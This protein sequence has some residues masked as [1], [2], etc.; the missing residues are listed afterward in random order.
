M[1]LGLLTAVGSGSFAMALVGAGAIA[2]SRGGKENFPYFTL[3]MKPVWSSVR[4]MWTCLA[5]KPRNVITCLHST[6]AEWWDRFQ[7]GSDH[8]PFKC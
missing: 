6:H 4:R 3:Q 5:N 1:A 8:L 7:P 2:T